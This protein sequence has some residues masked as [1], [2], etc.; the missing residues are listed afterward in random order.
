VYE[1][2]VYPESQTGATGMAM[3]AGAQASNLDKWQYGLASTSFR[4][5]LSGSY[6]QVLPR[7]VSVDE[8]GNEYEF[9]PDALGG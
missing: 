6:Q 9:I 8:A 2:V 7:Y 5:N 3:R 4:W 1:S